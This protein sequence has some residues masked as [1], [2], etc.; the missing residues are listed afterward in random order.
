MNNKKIRILNKNF[1][2]QSFSVYF[3]YKPKVKFDDF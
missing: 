1:P 2:E 3:Y